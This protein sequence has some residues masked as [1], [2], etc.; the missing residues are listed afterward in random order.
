MTIEQLAA[1]HGY[2]YGGLKTVI[3]K[4]LKIPVYTVALTNTMTMTPNKIEQ[5]EKEIA[6]RMLWR[7]NP[8]MCRKK[9]KVIGEN[10]K[11]PKRDRENDT[12]RPKEGKTY[13]KI[14]EAV[15]VL[16]KTAKEIWDDCF[17]G[18]L[19]WCKINGVL[20]VCV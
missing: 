7:S 12:T 15:T 16:G 10:G 18:R 17:N 3:R 11:M 1:K 20:A 2:T 6:R 5:V 19:D 14:A 4:A 13:I 9:E 8:I